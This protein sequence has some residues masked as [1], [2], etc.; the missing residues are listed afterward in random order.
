M[1]PLGFYIRFINPL[2]GK[3]FEEAYS[4]AKP[5]SG[6]GFLLKLDKNGTYAFNMVIP[7]FKGN[8]EPDSLGLKTAQLA[9]FIQGVIKPSEII[10]KQLISL[11]R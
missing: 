1:K 6:T 10:K 3:P 7:V 5:T 9:G 4:T 8:K 2:Y 11:F